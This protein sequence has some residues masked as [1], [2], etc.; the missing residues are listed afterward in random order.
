MLQ[1]DPP[2]ALPAGWGTRVP[3]RGSRR[4]PMPGDMVAILIEPAGPARG[5]TQRLSETPG[6][7]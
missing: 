7:W 1:S 6:E 2:R 4:R 3:I 5:A